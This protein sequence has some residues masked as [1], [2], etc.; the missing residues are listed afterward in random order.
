LAIPWHSK[1]LFKQELPKQVDKLWGKSE[2][3]H[4]VL[5]YD[6]TRALLAALEKTPSPSRTDVQKTM[7]ETNFKATG[8]TGVI[9]FKPNGDAYGGL[10]Q[11]QQENMHLVKVVRNTKTGQ[12]EFVPLSKSSLFKQS[13]STESN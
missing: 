12:I 9:S 2:N 1:S 10:R 13:K 6:A 3:W 11:R 5:S 7:A 8:V 4:T